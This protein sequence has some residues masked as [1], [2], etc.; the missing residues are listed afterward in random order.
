MDWSIHQL[1]H[2]LSAKFDVAH[3]ASLSIV[4]GSWATYV[5]KEKP[6]RFA[7][8]ARN[9]W[10]IENDN[11]EEAACEAIEKTVAFFQSLHMPTCFSASE[12]GIQSEEV[13]ADLA[14]RCSFYEKRLVG[15]F[16]QLSREDL[17][18]IYSS[19]NR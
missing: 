14:L 10:G 11:A 17:Y 4:W 16:K 9:V 3:P 12:F 15:Q 8:Y 13:I 19:A 6:E 7:R 2:E 1:G 18:H 5:Y